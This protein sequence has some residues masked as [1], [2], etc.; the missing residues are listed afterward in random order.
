MPATNLR[1]QVRNALRKQADHLVA[2][3]D[4]NLNE[5]DTVRLINV[6]F[7]K[8][9]GYDPFTELSSEVQLKNKYVDMAVKIDGQIRF[10]LEAKAAGVTLRDR[11]IE[12]AQNYA[13]RNN[14]T[15]VLLT[16]GLTWNLYHL[17]FEEGIE[18]ERAFSVDIQKD[19]VEKVADC[20]A[21]LHRASVRSGD[22]DGYW[23]TRVALSPSSI[24]SALFSE[25]VLRQIRRLIRQKEGL[26]TDIED[27]AQGIRDMLTPEAR[28]QIG[29]LRI[30]KASRRK[31]P[32]SPDAGT[33]PVRLV[34]VV[35]SSQAEE[36]S[37]PD[38]SS[39]RTTPG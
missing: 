9:L 11:H 15:W 28:E 6:I 24:G 37:S 25:D 5:A 19:G 30:R 35:D 1:T 20:L 26:L 32:D 29:P 27:L 33:A 23:N 13:S 21:L 34:G 7:E 10:L 8:V 12:Q 39:Q 16:N 4:G 3:R 14:Y 36:N 18:Y 2:A 22:L 17:T 31:K 38:A